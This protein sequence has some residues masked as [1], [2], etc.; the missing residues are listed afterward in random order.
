MSDNLRDLSS[1]LSQVD[2]AIQAA[3]LYADPTNPGAGFSDRLVE[4]VA[5]EEKVLERLIERARQAVSAPQLE[6]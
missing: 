4:L 1:E 6:S 3:P 5:Q 2:D